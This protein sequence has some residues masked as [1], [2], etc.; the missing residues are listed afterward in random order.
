[1]KSSVTKDFRKRLDQLPI[2]VR[3]QANN[4]YALWQED[5][6]HRSLQFKR[7]SQRQPIYSVRIGL[8]YRALGLLEDNHIFW[9]W[10]GPHAEYDE[11]LK[12]L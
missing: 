3:D 2:K 5:P 1:M 11:L 9:F 12:R 6:Y 8:N 4:A 7:V 10:I